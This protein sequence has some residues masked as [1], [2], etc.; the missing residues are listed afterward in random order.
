MGNVAR[1]PSADI[2]K[3][4]QS[5]NE[6]TSGA[7]SAGTQGSNE[8]SWKI[9]GMP[10]FLE[11]SRYWLQYAGMPDTLVYT[12]SNYRN[13]YNDDYQSRGFWV[14]Y[15]NEE[16]GLPVDLSLAFHSDAGI[17]PG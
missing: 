10:R 3:N 9:S 7:I 11:A 5:L 6:N 12:P 16:L 14:N 2:I 8:F 1:R 4:Q 17:T 15:L 13:D